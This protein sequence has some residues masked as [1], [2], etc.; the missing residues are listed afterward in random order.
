[1]GMNTD[2]L[3]EIQRERDIS[4]NE[5]AR[6]V[7]VSCPTMSNFMRGIREPRLSVFKQMCERLGKDPKELW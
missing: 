3:K 2:A 1:M 5:L 4:Q 6:F 7:G